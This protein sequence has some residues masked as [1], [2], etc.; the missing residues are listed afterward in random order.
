MEE[1]I[2]G[3][4]IPH[5]LLTFGDSLSLTSCRHGAFDR[6]GAVGCLGCRPAVPCLGLSGFDPSA[7]CGGAAMCSGGV[8]A[9]ISCVCGWDFL[10]GVPGVTI[11]SSMMFPWASTS[12]PV[13]SWFRPSVCKVVR[14]FMST[15]SLGRTS[16]NCLSFRGVLP[17][18]SF[19]IWASPNQPAAGRP[20]RL[21]G[22]TQRCG[23]RCAMRSAVC[24]FPPW[25]RMSP[26]GCPLSLPDIWMR[27][28]YRV[29]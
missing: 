4:E 17:K 21:Q 27:S 18:A 19:H 28:A 29:W 1:I 13:V 9:C 20:W 26:P 15:V 22:R 2:S 16:L 7:A 11:S 23:Q 5:F 6:A 8:S 14:S 24:N 10:L 25:M 3:P 12:V